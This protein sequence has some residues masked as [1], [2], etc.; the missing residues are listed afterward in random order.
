MA[1]NIHILCNLQCATH[2]IVIHGVTT[3]VTAPQTTHLGKYVAMHYR[4]YAIEQFFSYPQWID[5]ASHLDFVL[6]SSIPRI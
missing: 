5:M 2:V 6:M 3:H 1:W 4:K